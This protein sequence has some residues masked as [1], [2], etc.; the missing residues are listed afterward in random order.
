[1]TLRVHVRPDGSTKLVSRDATPGPGR[2]VDV[3]ATSRAEAEAVE[4]ESRTP[5]PSAHEI[6][7][8]PVA[9]R[10]AALAAR[11]SVELARSRCTVVREA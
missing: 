7:A 2:L 10:G 9:A 4:R 11:A 3:E 6:A 5:L 8:M 1:M